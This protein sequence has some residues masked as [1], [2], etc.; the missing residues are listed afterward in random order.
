MC[1]RFTLTMDLSELQALFPWIDFGID[2]KPRYNIAPSQSIAVVPNTEEKKVQLFRWGLIPHWAKD[3]S[4]G[5]KMINARGETVS[6]KPS[7]KNAYRKKRCLVL[8]D[9]FYEWKK[10]GKGKTPYLIRLKS[11][12]P[13]MFAGL[14]EKWHPPDDEPV[15]SCTIITT[16][17]NDLLKSIHHRMPVILSPASYDLWLDN[18][19]QP[20][21]RLDELLK[22]YT[23]DEMDAF[24]VSKIVNKPTND[25][26]D[27]INPAAEG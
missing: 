11:R 7:F 24:A 2:Y 8:A 25:I 19:P 21:T 26:Q 18:I 4:I 15:Y 14:W 12:K 27:C 10:E 13:I 17:A 5:H 9:G 6:E 22:P 16:E 1:G 20:A 23:D 3:P